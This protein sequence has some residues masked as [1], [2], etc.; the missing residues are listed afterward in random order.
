M[1]RVA[2][3]GGVLLLATQS[4]CSP[5]GGR[6]GAAPNIVKLGVPPG[7]CTVTVNGKQVSF[8][9][10]ARRIPDW[11]K[12]EAEVHFQPDPA[13]E[14]DCVDRAL[15]ELRKGNVTKLG[16]VGNEMYRTPE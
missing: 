9:E 3:I 16:F 2:F 5:D 1:R 10:L 12:T 7:P 8:D 15:G 6:I 14:F 13:A 4:A 11:V